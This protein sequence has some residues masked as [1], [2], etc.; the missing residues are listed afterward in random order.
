MEEL[1][2]KLKIEVSMLV[3]KKMYSGVNF[4]KEN[5]KD[6]S[7]ILW[8]STLLRPITVEEEEYICKEGEEI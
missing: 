3:H 6:K 7:F 2:H 5:E 1:P 8:I 4:F